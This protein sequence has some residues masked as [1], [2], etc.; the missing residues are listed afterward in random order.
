MH[1]HIHTHTL[2][3][4]HTHMLTRVHAQAL[5]ERLT[6]EAV[7]YNP[8]TVTFGYFKADFRWLDSGAITLNIY[9]QVGPRI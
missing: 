8:E 2:A 4:T 9:T 3:H 6:V 1:I 5:T 7:G